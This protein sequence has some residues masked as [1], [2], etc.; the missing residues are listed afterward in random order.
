MAR[1]ARRGAAVILQVGDGVVAGAPEDAAQ[2][3]EDE[4]QRLG[5][6]PVARVS[7]ARPPHD[8]RLRQIFEGRPRREHIVLLR[9]E[10]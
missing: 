7:Q 8:Y 5:L 1:V 4:A 6:T 3:V 9:K 2:T 10:H